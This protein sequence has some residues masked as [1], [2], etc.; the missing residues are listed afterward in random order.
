MKIFLRLLQVQSCGPAVTRSAAPHH[1][2]NV[3][4]LRD[5]GRSSSP[6]SC[7]T[8][9]W[10][11]ELPRIPSSAVPRTHPYINHPQRKGDPEAMQRYEIQECLSFFFST[12]EVRHPQENGGRR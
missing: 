9:A 2:W 1:D 4:D 8:E 12:N 3:N 5:E 7:A 6:H 11:D 10:K